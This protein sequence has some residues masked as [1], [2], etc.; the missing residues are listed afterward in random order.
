[1]GIYSTVSI[2][3]LLEVLIINESYYLY[4]VISLFRTPSMNFEQQNTRNRKYLR[5]SIAEIIVANP[6]WLIVIDRIS[7]IGTLNVDNGVILLI[8]CLIAVFS[9]FHMLY[10]IP[11]TTK[12]DVTAFKSPYNLML[13]AALRFIFY[14]FFSTTLLFHINQ[15]IRHSSWLTFVVTV[16]AVLVGIGVNKRIHIS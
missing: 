14:L 7:V 3:F 1:M 12:H 4:E 5:L 6:M 10:W 2:V 16:L 9:I 15:L 11:K 8:A 13:I